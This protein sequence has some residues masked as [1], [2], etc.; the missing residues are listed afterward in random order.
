MLPLNPEGERVV[1][2]VFRLLAARGRAVRLA[3]ET[4]D[5]DQLAGEATPPE[6]VATESAPCPL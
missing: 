5:V 6:V 2:E 3:Q 4:G 1:I